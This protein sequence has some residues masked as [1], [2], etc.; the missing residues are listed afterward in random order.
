MSSA[1]PF[2]Y[3]LYRGD[4][5]LDVGTI[6]QLSNR[7]GIKENTVRYLASNK[8]CE[9]VSSRKA[10]ENGSLIAFKLEESEEW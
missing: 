1:K 7:L 4:E 8:H 10:S 3:A 5:F 2:E 9:R 6:R